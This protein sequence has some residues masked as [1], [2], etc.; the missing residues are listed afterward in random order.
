MWWS[1]CF[2]LEHLTSSE[3][4]QS[5]NTVSKEPSSFSLPRC[6]TFLIKLEFIGHT[7]SSLVLFNNKFLS[8]SCSTSI[9]FPCCFPICICPYYLILYDC[10]HFCSDC[11][12]SVD[13]INLLFQTICHSSDNPSALVISSPTVFIVFLLPYKADKI[14]V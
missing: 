6:L 8:A 13:G 12:F 11:N 5:T 7:F 1:V 9:Q 14:S 3:A 4:M 2:S 10:S